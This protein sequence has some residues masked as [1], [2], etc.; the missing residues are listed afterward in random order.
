[1]YIKWRKKV[2][3]NTQVSLRAYLVK[4]SWVEG[5]NKKEVIGYLGAIREGQ[6]ETAR[7]KSLDK[8]DKKLKLLI[9]DKSL[10]SKIRNDLEKVAPDPRRNLRLLCAEIMKRVR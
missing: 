9:T 1:M 4:S 3:E 2:L 7:I 10:Y 8:I 5:K 6:P